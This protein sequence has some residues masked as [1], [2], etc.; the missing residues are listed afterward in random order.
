MKLKFFRGFPRRVI[1]MLFIKL[2]SFAAP[3][4]HAKPSQKTFNEK[5][6]GK[7]RNVVQSIKFLWF[8]FETFFSFLLRMQQMFIVAARLWHVWY[9]EDYVKSWK[10][11]SRN[12]EQE[13]ENSWFRK[14]N[15]FLPHNKFEKNDFWRSYWCLMSCEISIRVNLVC[16]WRVSGNNFVMT[17]QK[18]LL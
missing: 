13:D 15:I 4:V 2:C 18:I 9:K 11:Y 6:P 7:L 12:D 3:F 8:S 10:Y 16:S 14:S 17:C 5:L 1:F